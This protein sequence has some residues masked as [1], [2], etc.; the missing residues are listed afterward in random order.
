MYRTCIQL[1]I[2]LVAKTIQLIQLVKKEKP[3]IPS[4]FEFYKFY[5]LAH[6]CQQVLSQVL[7][8]CYTSCIGVVPQA[9]RIFRNKEFANMRKFPAFGNG[10]PQGLATENWLSGESYC[11][12]DSIPFMLVATCR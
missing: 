9:Y 7:Y 2:E 4:P 10:I 6:Y 3:Q 12:P 8:E 1:A 5:R 11:P